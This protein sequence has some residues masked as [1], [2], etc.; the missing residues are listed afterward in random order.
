MAG[1]AVIHKLAPLRCVAAGPLRSLMNN[2]ETDIG[3]AQDLPEWA[4]FTVDS[5]RTFRAHRKPQARQFE[6]YLNGSRALPI[7]RMAYSTPKPLML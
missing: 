7:T 2:C 5:G 4:V 3:A 6:R 1:G